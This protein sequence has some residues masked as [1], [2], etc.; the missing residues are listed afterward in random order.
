MLSEKVAEYEDEDAAARQL[1]SIVRD[2]VVE[3][4]LGSPEASAINQSALDALALLFAD[5]KP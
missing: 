2:V 5:L 4:K 1:H 3:S